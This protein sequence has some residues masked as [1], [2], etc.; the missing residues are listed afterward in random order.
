MTLKVDLNVA[1]TQ[2]HPKMMQEAIAHPKPEMRYPH[3]YCLQTIG[4]SGKMQVVNVSAGGPICAKGF[5]KLGFVSDKMRSEMLATESAT[6]VADQML[7]SGLHAKQAGMGAVVV[8]GLLAGFGGI[9]LT[10]APFAVAVGT[11]AILMGGIAGL[12]I[13]AGIALIIFSITAEKEG[14]GSV[15]E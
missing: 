8:G 4:M 2:L 1:A 11:Q 6:G 5:Q 14:G 15:H 10:D 9:L 3:A 13:M 12:C 7:A